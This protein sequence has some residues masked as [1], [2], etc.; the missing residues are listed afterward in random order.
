LAKPPVRFFIS[1]GGETKIEAE[2][3]FLFFVFFFSRPSEQKTEQK[4]SSRLQVL[5]RGALFPSRGFCPFLWLSGGFFSLPWLERKKGKRDVDPGPFL[6]ADLADA[7][8]SKL[9]CDEDA[10]SS[11][12]WGHEE[13]NRGERERA[14]R[15]EKASRGGRWG[16]ADFDEKTLA[17]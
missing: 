6:A 12:H 14:S 1:E 11:T 2:V 15:R 10:I 17:I 16:M 9:F 4:K 3:E 7:L 5:P 13:S 8:T